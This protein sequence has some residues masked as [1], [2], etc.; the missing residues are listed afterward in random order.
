[1][2]NWV[3]QKSIEMRIIACDAWQEVLDELEKPNGQF[4]PRH[5]TSILKGIANKYNELEKE[6]SAT[7]RELKLIV[8]SS[9]EIFKV[10]CQEAIETIKRKAA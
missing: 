2:T 4:T 3:D 9:E 10:A 8:K 5:A 7:A 6:A 1:M